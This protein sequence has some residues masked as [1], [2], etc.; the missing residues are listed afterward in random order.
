[1]YKIKKYAIMNSMFKKLVGFIGCI[2]AVA[3]VS[4]QTYTM[5]SSGTNTITACGGT[6]LDPGGTSTYANSLSS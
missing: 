2:L 1:M 4:A 3:C 5:P 6:V